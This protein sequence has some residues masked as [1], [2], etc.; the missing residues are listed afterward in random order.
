M[1][2]LDKKIKHKKN[3]NKKGKKSSPD[4]VAVASLYKEDIGFEGVKKKRRMLV[5][6]DNVGPF[7]LPVNEKE[8]SKRQK[9]M[10]RDWSGSWR[11]RFHSLVIT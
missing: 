9:R 8:E 5:T 10:V 2:G 6:N 11:V 4:N 3:K 7:E 1:S